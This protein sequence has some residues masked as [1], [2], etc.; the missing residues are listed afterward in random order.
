MES[1]A[2]VFIHQDHV[3]RLFDACP[4][5]ILVHVVA[6]LLPQAPRACIHVHIPG[7]F[8]HWDTPVAAL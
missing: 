5:I 8:S 6:P 3:N 2:N 4:D 1:N 7:G